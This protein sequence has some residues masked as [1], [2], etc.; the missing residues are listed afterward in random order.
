EGQDWVEDVRGKQ[1]VRWTSMTLEA[2]KRPRQKKTRGHGYDWEGAWGYATSLR[3][4]DQWDWKQL[5]RD[6]KQ[7]LPALRKVVEQKIVEWFAAKGAGPD[8]SDIRQNITIPL[9]A[10]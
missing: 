4:E 6:K 5:G 1:R 10:G 9:Y 3:A 2:A 7:P 8:I